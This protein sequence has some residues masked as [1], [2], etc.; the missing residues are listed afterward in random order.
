MISHAE[1]DGLKITIKNQDLQLGNIHCISEKC[2]D[3]NQKVRVVD[4]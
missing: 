4:Y 2:S 1:V 3:L